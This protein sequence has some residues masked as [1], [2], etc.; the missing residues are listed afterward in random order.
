MEGSLHSPPCVLD[1]GNPC[2]YDG[3]VNS[4]GLGGTGLSVINL[5]RLNHQ[6]LMYDECNLDVKGFFPFLSPNRIMNTDPPF[7]HQSVRREKE[8]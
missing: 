7:S 6:C 2:W 5:P 1:T 8:L 3:C 4:I